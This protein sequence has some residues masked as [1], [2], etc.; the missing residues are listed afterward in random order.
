MKSAVLIALLGASVCLGTVQARAQYAQFEVSNLTLSG[1]DPV[2]PVTDNV[3]FQNLTLSETFADSATRNLTLPSSLDAFTLLADSPT[4][5]TPDPV[6]GAISSAT[7]SGN[8]DLSSLTLQNSFGGT[9][10]FVTVTNPAF[11]AMLTNPGI[12]DNVN[13][14]VA[15]SSG[16]VNVGAFSLVTA[17]PEPGTFAF[18]AACAGAAPLVLRRRGRQ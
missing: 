13:F 3:T 7:L 8:I 1:G 4:F 14:A 18:L 10:M 9:T 2:F 16:T 6:H 11:S 17:V 12:G 5:L 15:T